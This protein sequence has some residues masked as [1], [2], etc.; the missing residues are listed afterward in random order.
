M[1]WQKIKLAYG[2]THE[3][4]LGNCRFKIIRHQKEWQAGWLRNIPGKKAKNEYDW[5]YFIYDKPEL[6]ILP[7]LP[8]KPLVLKPDYPLRILPKNNMVNYIKVPVWVQFYAGAVKTEN[9]VM[10][11]PA[12][13]LSTTWFGEPDNGELAYSLSHPAEN[14]FRKPELGSDF[15]ICPIS[16]SNESATTL[17]FQR[18]L[19]SV[20]YLSIFNDGDLLCSNETKVRYKGEQH[21][22]EVTFVQGKPNLSK[23]LQHLSSPRDTS[24]KSILRKS[25]SLIMNLSNI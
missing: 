4:A 25:F 2:E 6:N 19:V 22:S 8:D 18:F 7:S 24:T 15:V 13:E 20:R 5:I 14:I 3:F 16:I 17:D 23:D 12:D 9:L 1:I 21:A 11:C 10:E